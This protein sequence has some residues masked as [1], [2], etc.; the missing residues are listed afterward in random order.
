MADIASLTAVN[1]RRWSNAKVPVPAVFGCSAAKP[2]TIA[3]PKS[4]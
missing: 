2:L 4:G 1:A 3:P